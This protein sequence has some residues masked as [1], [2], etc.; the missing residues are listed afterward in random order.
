MQVQAVNGQKYT[1]A[2]L[3]EAI[4]ASEQSQEPIKLL[5][6]RG[7]EFTTVSL[8]YHGGMRYPHLE[9]VETTPDRLDAIL[10]PAE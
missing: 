5:L 3:R 8:E 7:D 2:I 9:R 4:L 1:A 6:R 10:A